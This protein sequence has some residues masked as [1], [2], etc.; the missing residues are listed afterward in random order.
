MIFYF[1][2]GEISVNIAP[3]V[4]LD[5]NNNFERKYRAAVNSDRYNALIKPLQDKISAAMQ[6]NDYRIMA[7]SIVAPRQADHV[8]AVHVIDGHFFFGFLRR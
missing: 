4:P 6:Q 2:S 1:Y 8:G 3:A 7:L 5:I